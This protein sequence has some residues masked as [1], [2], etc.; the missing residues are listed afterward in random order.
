MQYQIIQK[1]V[2][3][4]NFFL[5][6]FRDW[7]AVW[8]CSPLFI[9]ISAYLRVLLGTTTRKIILLL[10]QTLIHLGSDLSITHCCLLPNVFSFKFKKLVIFQNIFRDLRLKRVNFIL[11]KV[12]FKRNQALSGLVLHFNQGRFK[13]HFL[14]P[15][16]AALFISEFEFS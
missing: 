1:T 8:H 10:R 3:S 12:L 7:L 11:E 2:M 9:G 5:I 13:S 14:F 15:I 16:K 6:S 4:S